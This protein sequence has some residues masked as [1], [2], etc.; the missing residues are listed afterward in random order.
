MQNK[1]AIEALNTYRK[2]YILETFAN[3][4]LSYMIISYHRIVF[5][6]IHTDIQHKR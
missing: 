3:I 6:I 5:Y 1:C 2:I 4:R